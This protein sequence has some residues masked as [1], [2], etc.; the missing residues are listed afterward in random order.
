MYRRTDKEFV[1][2][3]YV[4]CER[5]L[6]YTSGMK[7]EDFVNDQKTI[8]AVIRNVEILG[9]ATKNLSA[10]FRAQFH[11]IEWNLIARTRDKLIHYYFGLDVEVLMQIIK[12]DIPALKEKLKEV[13]NKKGW[14]D[15]T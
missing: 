13:I 9:E 2:D 14:K 3:M 11:E 7:F 5:I 4:A 6:N 8:D 1:L 10:D 15:E 12:R